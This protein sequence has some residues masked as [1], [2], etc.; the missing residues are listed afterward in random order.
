MQVAALRLVAGLYMSALNT[1][2]TMLVE[3]EMAIQ[4]ASNAQ[5]PMPADMLLATQYR[6]EKKR[7]PYEG[8]QSIAKWIRVGASLSWLATYL[9]GHQCSL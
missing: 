7:L 4:E 1:F 2:P 9:H 6:A 5:R 3:D 8:L